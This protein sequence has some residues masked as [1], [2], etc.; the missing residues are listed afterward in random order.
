MKKIILSA[1][2]AASALTAN[3]QV[4][5]GGALGFNSNK[6]C[7]GAESTTA[8]TLAPTIGYNINEN[9]AVLAEISFNSTNNAG[10][11]DPE[12]AGMKMDKS[13]STLGLGVYG[14]YTFA[15]TGIASFFV[16][17]GV[18]MTSMNNDRGA[19]FSVGLR[20]GIK[21]SAS[22]KV[23][24]VATIGALRYQF[25]NEKAGKGNDLYLG[26]DNTNIALGVY[27]NF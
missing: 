16:D 3:A 21:L 26:V 20:P 9:W 27:Y 11:F 18:S 2:V 14:R 10:A 13:A 25:A 23:D 17:G 19:I 8:F 22:E 7:D 24:L 15:K 6:F 5:V 12:L 4:F 1:L